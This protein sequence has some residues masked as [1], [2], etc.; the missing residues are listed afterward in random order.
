MKNLA[1]LI[2]SITLT[3]C[4][5]LV[6]TSS[7]TYYANEHDARGSISVEP[8]TE[9][10][11]GSLEFAH[12]KNFLEQR[13]LEQG[14]TQNTPG[15]TPQYIA[16]VTYG[17]DAG[18]TKTSSVPIYGQTGG[19]TTFTSGSF[20]SGG[21]FGTY[22]GTSMTMPTYG[23]VGSTTVTNKEY[24][25]EVNINIWRNNNP[26]EKIYEMKGV[27]RGSCGK[28]DAV[29]ESIIT[30]MFANFP[31]KSGATQRVNV[32]WQGQC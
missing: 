2:A 16:F 13:L 20:S 4:T 10:Q 22:S 18:T 8:Y 15:T 24:L 23:V 11:R 26:P 32:P 27:S 12:V 30:G 9:S 6:Q 17:I 3:G 5:S 31:G 21:T 28:I 7:I 14:F 19:G 1:L 25:R 29:V